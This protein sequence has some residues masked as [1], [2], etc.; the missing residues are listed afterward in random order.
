M[1]YFDFFSTNLQKVTFKLMHSN[2]II[3]VTTRGHLEVKKEKSHL[4]FTPYLNSRVS[5]LNGITDFSLGSL[6]S[7]L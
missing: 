1:T 4:P 7:G 6:L 3:T 5:P 2:A